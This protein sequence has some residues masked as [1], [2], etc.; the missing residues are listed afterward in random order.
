[1]NERTL[2][3]AWFF[4]PLQQRLFI[5]LNHSLKRVSFVL[6]WERVLIAG[7]LTIPV[8]NIKNKKIA[9]YFSNKTRARQR[10]RVSKANNLDD[11]LS[12]TY[13]W[14]NDARFKATGLGDFH[15]CSTTRQTTT[16]EN[17]RK[18]PRGKP[19]TKTCKATN[20]NLIHKA[21]KMV[22]IKHLRKQQNHTVQAPIINRYM[23]WGDKTKSALHFFVMTQRSCR[24]TQKLRK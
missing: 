22:V 11:F 12:R 1:M 9:V 17:L 20:R 23:L 7:G 3:H 16:V 2:L 13:T 6:F 5:K 15:R 10:K 19:F 21:D 18:I 24:Y 14:W 4:I 8:L